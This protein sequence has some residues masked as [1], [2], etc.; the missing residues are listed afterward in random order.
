VQRQHQ[1]ALAVEPG[2]DRRDRQP[3]QVR[4][5]AFEALLRER[6]L[7]GVGMQEVAPVDV[8]AA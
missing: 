4:L 2:I 8:P 6:P 7:A 3:G 1:R 5:D